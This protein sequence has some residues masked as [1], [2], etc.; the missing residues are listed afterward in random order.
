ML[1]KHQTTRYMITQKQDFDGYSGASPYRRVL[2]SIRKMVPGAV[3]G[4]RLRSLDGTEYAWVYRNAEERFAGDV[5][6]SPEMEELRIPPTNEQ[7]NAIP[8][9][10]L[11]WGNGPLEVGRGCHPL[12]TGLT[13]SHTPQSTLEPV[14]SSADREHVTQCDSQ[15]Q[16]I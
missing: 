6:S 7:E 11:V 3:R 15:L 14:L 13:S 10:L 4:C 16:S 2:D 5:R 1:A 8:I 12:K 9:A